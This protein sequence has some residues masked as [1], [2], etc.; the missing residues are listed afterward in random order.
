MTNI[1]DNDYTFEAVLK[2]DKV[3]IDGMKQFTIP[4]TL[5]EMSRAK[6]LNPEKC[7]RIGAVINGKSPARERNDETIFFSA[8]G[9]GIHDLILGKIIYDRAIQKGIG[10]HL[11]LWEKPYWV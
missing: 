5:G 8:L 11:T 3:V 6:L 4:V 9:M 2:A 7:L 1:S 10:T